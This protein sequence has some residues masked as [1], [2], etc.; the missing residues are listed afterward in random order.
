MPSVFTKASTTT[1]ESIAST[2]S[3]T[4]TT[5]TEVSQ[6]ASTVNNDTSKHVM[7][8][9]RD[10]LGIVTTVSRNGSPVQKLIRLINMST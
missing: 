8:K 7:T 1:T 4:S 3:K 10:E 5:T 9:S 6:I 2:K